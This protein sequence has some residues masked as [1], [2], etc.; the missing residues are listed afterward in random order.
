LLDLANSTADARLNNRWSSASLMLKAVELCE[1]AVS[2]PHCDTKNTGSDKTIVVK[3]HIKYPRG[4]QQKTK[5]KTHSS[6]VSSS[7][8][9][10]DQEKMM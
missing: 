2:R 1:N 8:Q 10:I 9:H 5:T 4:E 6:A 3:K 7:R